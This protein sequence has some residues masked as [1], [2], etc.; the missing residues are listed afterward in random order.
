[1]VL[2]SELQN[3]MAGHISSWEQSGLGKMEYCR[4]SG[5]AFSRFSY[6]LRKLRP[7]AQPGSGFVRIKLENEPSGNGSGRAAEVILPSGARVTFFH[8]VDAGLLKSLLF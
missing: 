4:Q 3:E 5:L 8:P 1:M 2:K 6:W 7:R